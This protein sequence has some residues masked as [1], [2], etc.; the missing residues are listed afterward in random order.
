[1][2]LD[3]VRLVVSGLDFNLGELNGRYGETPYLYGDV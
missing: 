3:G 2:L 1:M